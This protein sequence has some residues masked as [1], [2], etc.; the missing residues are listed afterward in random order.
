MTRKC[1]ATDINKIVPK[2]SASLDGYTSLGIHANHMDMTKFSSNQDPD[3]R[4]VLSELQRFVQS[5]EQQTKEKLPL[6]S[7]MSPKIQGKSVH[8]I[9][10]ENLVEERDQNN[11]PEGEKP[12]RP[13]K[14]INNFSG[15]FYTGGGKV[16]QGNE[17]Y[18]GGGSMTF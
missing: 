16:I 7:S 8:G 17:F 11:V 18:S 10:N 2:H 4:N 9:G 5:C 3:Y 6:A 14:L 13:K 12:S 1:P 15:T